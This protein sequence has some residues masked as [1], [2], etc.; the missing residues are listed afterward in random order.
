MFIGVMV[1]GNGEVNSI[2]IEN[3][4]VG[5]SLEEVKARIEETPLFLNFLRKLGDCIEIWE[6][7][8]GNTSCVAVY[9]DDGMGKTEW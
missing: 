3:V 5:D 9:N 4:I 2:G 6:H 8:D 1:Y 7:K